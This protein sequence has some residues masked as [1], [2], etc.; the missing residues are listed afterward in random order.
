MSHTSGFLQII[1]WQKLLNFSHVFL[2]LTSTDTLPP[3]LGWMLPL[4]H[5]TQMLQCGEYKEP[6]RHLIKEKGH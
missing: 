4:A 1:L 6:T 3:I 5:S 2:A